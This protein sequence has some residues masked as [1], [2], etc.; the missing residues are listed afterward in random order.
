MNRNGPPQDVGPHVGLE[1]ARLANEANDGIEVFGWKPKI[2]IK[3]FR[4]AVVLLQWILKEELLA[5]ER[6]GPLGVLCIA[7]IHPSMFFVSITNMP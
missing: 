4:M 6:L 1:L 5:V 3:R 7:K 2:P